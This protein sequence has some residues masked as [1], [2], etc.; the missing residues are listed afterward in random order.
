MAN[1]Y[2]DTINSI[3]DTKQIAAHNLRDTGASLIMGN[4]MAQDTPNCTVKIQPISFW[5]KEQEIIHYFGGNSGL[6]KIPING[7]KWVLVGLNSNNNPASV[8]LIEG[9][10]V[11]MGSIPSYPIPTK[12]ILPLALVYVNESLTYITNANIYDIRPLFSCG[13]RTLDHSD[14]LNR[15]VDNSHTIESITNLRSELDKIISSGLEFQWT[16][17]SLGVK[18]ETDEEFI[19]Q[20]L[21][22]LYVP[23][24]PELWGDPAPTNVSE[25]LDIL[26]QKVSALTIV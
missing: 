19:F 6:I 11:P 4:V 23:T 12:S 17:T 2:E 21:S 15:N 5:N 24:Q 14:L 7:C 26:I 18:K 22:A 9:Q 1:S 16:G 8:D 20:D 10:T 3:N 25:A 13:S